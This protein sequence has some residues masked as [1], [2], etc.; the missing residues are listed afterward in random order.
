MSRAEDEHRTAVIQMASAVEHSAIVEYV[1]ADVLIAVQA[2]MEEAVLKMSPG[3][4]TPKLF[5]AREQL[6]RL[7]RDREK[8][9]Q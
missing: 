5:A 4:T 9:E 3:Y 2:A 7:K 8:L 1:D 6:T